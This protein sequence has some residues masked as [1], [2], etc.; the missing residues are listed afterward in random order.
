[1]FK[2]LREDIAAIK[3]RDP[4]ARS[5]ISVFFSY[6]GLHAVMFYRCAHKLRGWRLT[7]LSSLIS[8]I[9]RIITGI[10]IHPGATIGRRFFIDHGTGVVI[11]ETAEIGDD[12]TLY[13]GVT[14]GGTS[15]EPGKR[16]PTVLDG[17]IVGAGAKVLG[18]ITVGKNA[19][20]GSNAVVLKDVAENTTVVGI[21]AKPVG[22]PKA[23][24]QPAFVAYG[25]P[26]DDLPDP[27]ARA[28]RGLS[29]E[30]TALRQRLATLEDQSKASG[31]EGSGVAA[32]PERDEA[33]RAGNR[34]AV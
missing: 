1:M 32:Q 5:S 25:T 16:H 28:L 14:L 27:V 26:C 20:V 18:P 13:Q 23:A 30:V 31:D 29:E 11:G 33:Q 4:A 21:P 24:S 22:Q 9:G 34:R 15:L 12:V 8:Y 17:A 2:R 6:P 7:S 19:R 3:A 10:E